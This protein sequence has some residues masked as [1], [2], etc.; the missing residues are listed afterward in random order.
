MRNKLAGWRSFVRGA[1]SVMLTLSLTCAAYAQQ[2][3]TPRSVNDALDKM[4]L[5]YE[6][7]N[8]KIGGKYDLANATS[9][10]NGAEGGTTLESLGAGPARTAYIAVGTP[11]KNN[12]GEIINAIVI[13]SY[14][15]GD[16]TAMY[17]NWY[18]GQAGNAF[19]GGALVGPGLLFDT[20]RFYVVFVD[21]LGL[22][23]A[24]KPSDGLGMKFPVYSYYD[25]VQ[26]NYR[27]L[28][29]KLNIGQVV[30]ATGASMGGTQ[31]YYWGLM[32]PGFV[33]AVMPIGG[34]SATDGEGPVAAWTFQLAKAAL[35][36]DPV[37][38]E[39]KGD[40]YK[41]PK[42]QHPNKGVEFHWSM[43]SLTG[44]QLNYRQSLGWE[45]VSK[46]VFT[47]KDDPRMGKDAGANLKRLASQFDGV[48]LWYRDTVGEIHNI[49]KLL[50]G[51][52]A[53]T[54]V[55]HIDNDQWLISDKAKEAAQLIPGGQY[56]GFPDKTA[57]YAVFKA[58]NSLKT[59]PTFDTF[60]RD[61]GVIS[62]KTIVCEAKNYRSPKINMKPD[63]NKSFWKDEMVSPFP[64]KYA[65]VKDKRGVE[66]EIGY[67]DEYCGKASNPPTLV[68][69]HGKGAFGAHYGYLIKYAVER[70]YRVIAPDMPQWGMS[71]PGN[72]DKPMTRTLN[73]VRDAFHALVVGK[74]G[75]NKAFY[76]GH[77]LG[78]QTVIGYAML[79]P[80]AVQGLILEGP[81]GLEEYPKSIEMNGKSYPICDPS[82]AYDLK[83][84]N[85]AYEP[86][87]LVSSEINKTPQAVED[88]FY[89]RKRD[90]AGNVTASPA[91][92][93]F[94]DTEYAR[95]HTNQR[96]AM[97]TGNKR[98]FEQWAFMF[99]YDLYSICSENVKEDPN[100][101]YK[102][103]PT[104]KAPIFLTFGAK[105]PFIP[106]T[107]L[108]G[109]TDMAKTIV[110]PFKQ[111]MTFAGNPPTIKVY[112]NVGHFIHTDV[113]YEFAKDTV[114]FMRSGKVDLMSADVIEALI[115][116]VG[117]GAAA[118]AAASSGKPSG[119]AK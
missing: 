53:R 23:G 16:A 68:V 109:L 74:L 8:F 38:V 88:F 25:V 3:L 59:N 31:A 61:I 70:G 67:M 104:I 50:P 1:V 54:L 46:E 107:A 56:V 89:F 62:D 116:P 84:W 32:Y 117:E 58:P 64:V 57:H 9:F 73:D 4:K 41:L 98:E 97:M 96:I 20:D 78:G 55:V 76:H 87:G 101:I 30:L 90:A 83:A 12:K 40:Y 112:P 91:G 66:W 11:K 71:G 6:V 45:A 18:A 24:S 79:Y 21:A 99:T 35:E 7:K 2:P 43:L 93:F 26:L 94:N 103:L 52:Q 115:N 105:E 49:N 5:T 106:G 100:S 60:M 44:Y 65:K 110:I 69:V 37:W 86:M 85:A 75:V 95:L 81:A 34:A 47:W 108:N 119:L 13:N 77:S 113:P 51:M 29:D 92:Y 17:T 114:D 15:S 10:E 22:W 42:D 33:K 19:S 72:I 39:T 28:R 102:R 63:P 36:S 27:L 80:N 48:D 82:I 14:Y 118:P 111:R